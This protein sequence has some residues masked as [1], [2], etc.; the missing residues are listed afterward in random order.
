MTL[1]ITSL[2][3]LARIALD[4]QKCAMLSNDL[5]TILELV[6]QLQSVD[7]TQIAPLAHPFEDHQ[8]L[9]EDTV[10]ETDQHQAFQTLAS[11]TEAGL[12]LVP[13]VIED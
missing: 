3:K 10:T 11:E 1:N 7:T 2:A 12:Y 4:E 9:R 6:A 8:R 13:S 5:N